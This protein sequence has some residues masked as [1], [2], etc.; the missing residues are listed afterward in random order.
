MI[1]YFHSPDIADP[2]FSPSTQGS[3]KEHAH[4]EKIVT[5]KTWRSTSETHGQHIRWPSRV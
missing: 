2:R 5:C 3:V 1:K 4:T